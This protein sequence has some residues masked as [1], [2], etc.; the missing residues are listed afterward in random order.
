MV[1][2]VAVLF[3]VTGSVT[4][5][6]TLAVPEITVPLPV[7]LFTW[8]ASE[9]LAAEPPSTLTFAQTTVPVAPVFGDEHDQPAAG[10][11]DTN[12]V[13]AGTEKTSVALSAELGPI[14]FTVAVYVILLFAATGSGEA[15]SPTDKSAIEI[16]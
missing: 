4:L 1:A 8:T 6:V 13:F 14:L 11:T 2:A 15:A 5:D 3:A 16:T 9:K 12:V 7:P 10:V